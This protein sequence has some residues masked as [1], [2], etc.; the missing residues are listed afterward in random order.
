[1]WQA[2]GLTGLSKAALVLGVFPLALQLMSGAG[3]CPHRSGAQMGKLHSCRLPLSPAGLSNMA[4]VLS[5]GFFQGWWLRTPGGERDRERWTPGCRESL[6][7]CL[8]LP[9]KLWSPAS[10]LSSRQSQNPAQLPRRWEIAE[11]FADSYTKDGI[12]RLLTK[13][14][15]PY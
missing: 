4:A 13:A 9:G 3:L 11:Q 10:L 5:P 1:M 2:H 7:P 8:S 6:P 14:K 12:V 15:S